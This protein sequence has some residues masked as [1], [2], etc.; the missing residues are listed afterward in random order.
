MLSVSNISIKNFRSIESAEISLDKINALVGINSSGKS[1]VLKA[2]NSFFNLDSERSNFINGTH[3]YNSRKQSVIEVTFK[4][5]HVSWSNQTATKVRLTYTGRSFTYRYFDISSN[6]FVNIT[7]SNFNE[8]FEKISFV[9]I[10]TRRDHTVANQGIEGLLHEAMMLWLDQKNIKRDNWSKRISSAGTDFISSAL[11]GFQ[12]K[13]TETVLL[14]SNEKYKIGFSDDIDYK[15]LLPKLEI[16]VEEGGVENSL[17]E[18][19]SG[20]Q[21]M[22]V[23]ALYSF[24][25]EANEK[26]YILG[27]E[28]PEQNLHPQAQ[29]QLANSLKSLDL[30]VLFTTHSPA[31][32]DTLEHQNIVLCKKIPDLQRGFKTQTHQ[33]QDL[34]FQENGI[35]ID[36]YKKF[37]RRRNS[38]FFFSRYLIIVESPNDAEL[39]DEL[40]RI[41]RIDVQKSGGKILSADSKENFRFMHPLTNELSIPTLYIADKDFFLKQR[42][43]QI[44]EI[45][46]TTHSEITKEIKKHDRNGF[47]IY[48][49]E[50]QNNSFVQSLFQSE[51]ERNTICTKLFRNH[52]AALDSLE[53][54]RFLSMK[55]ALEHEL[56]ST[57]MGLNAAIDVLNI[58][59]QHQ[60]NSQYI[61]E[62]KSSV[63]KRSSTLIDILQRLDSKNYPRTFSRIIKICKDIEIETNIS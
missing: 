23:L 32:I 21:S 61:L 26:S 55:Y 24:M 10:P 11:S 25:A 5:L 15:I 14:P 4:N 33:I 52:T 42:K 43:E 22:A 36:S 60:Q 2:L 48:L 8:I 27:F 57:T 45:N 16:K 39:I 1:A 44:T 13:L 62:N 41:N 6:K 18:T 40:L 38:D 20:S 35:N 47:P 50:L 51:N 56:L 46:N 3:S 37:H 53:P 30:Q 34:F 19:G 59:E 9:F 28:E 54:I 58:R 12:D 31:I 29:Q 63:I 17:S 49:P 7:Q